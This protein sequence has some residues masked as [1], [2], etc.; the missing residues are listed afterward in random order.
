LKL[1][2]KLEPESASKRRFQKTG[3]KFGKRGVSKR[4]PSQSGLR[5]KGP[6]EKEKVGKKIGQQ[7][8]GHRVD[9]V[10][11]GKARTRKEGTWTVEAA[12]MELFRDRGG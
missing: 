7:G 9:F 12:E 8:S 10:P 4:G 1:L 2:G 11:N 5:A 6:K 3:G